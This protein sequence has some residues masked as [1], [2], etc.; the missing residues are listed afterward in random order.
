MIKI[1][2]LFIALCIYSIVHSQV[3]IKTYHKSQITSKGLFG[4]TDQFNETIISAMDMSQMNTK[5][6]GR[7]LFKFAVPK[8]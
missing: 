5:P 6:S 2:I 1:P 7:G 4:K 3:V 8:Y